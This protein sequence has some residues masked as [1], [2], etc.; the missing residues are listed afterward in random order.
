[1]VN[2]ADLVDPSALQQILGVYASLGYRVLVTS[3]ASGLNVDYLRQLLKGKQTAL[4]GTRLRLGGVPWQREQ[5]SSMSRAWEVWAKS[6]RST[7]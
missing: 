5:E 2:K 4:A 3:A 6:P 1:M 7:G